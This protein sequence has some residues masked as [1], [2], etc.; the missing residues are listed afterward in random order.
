MYKIPLFSFYLTPPTCTMT[1]LCVMLN[2]YWTPLNPLPG[3]NDLNH[4]T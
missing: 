2:M 3:P 1:H 4:L